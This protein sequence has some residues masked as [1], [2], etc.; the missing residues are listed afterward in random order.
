VSALQFPNPWTAPLNFSDSLSHDLNSPNV[1]V[2]ETVSERFIAEYVDTTQDVDFAYRESLF[3]AISNGV[4]DEVTNLLSNGTY[5]H[6]RDGINNSPL[7][8][9]ILKGN[10]T[11]VK[12]LLDY[13]ADIDAIGFKRKTPLHLATTSKPLV[14][15]LL[16]Y[17][18]K[19]SL[20]DDEGNTALHY[21]LNPKYLWD[22]VDWSTFTNSAPIIKSIL[23]SGMDI[24]ITNRLGDSALHRVMFAAIPNSDAYMELVSEF[25]NHN[26]DLSSPMRNGLSPLYVFLNKSEIF[27]SPSNYWG[28]G[29]PAWVKR[30]YMCLEKFLAAGADPNTIFCSKPLIIE[31]L[32]N[33]I[34]MEDDMTGKA[35]LKLI[36]KASIDVLG[37]AGNGPLHLALGRVNPQEN[38]R[39][40][41]WSFGT[42]E[43]T[44]ALISRNANVNQTNDD[45]ASP[46]EILL[47]KGRHKSSTIVKVAS[48]LIEAGADTMMPT[49]TGGTLFDMLDWLPNDDQNLLTKAFL[50]G[51]AVA[52]DNANN[53]P[54]QAEWVEIWRTAWEKLRWEGAKARLGELQHSRSRP[55]TAHFME[56]ASLVLTEHQLEMHKSEL[57][58]WQDKLVEKEMVTDDYEDYCAILRDCRERGIEID[59]SWYAFLLDLM[60]FK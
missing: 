44:A 22:Y 32:S 53:S 58:R 36:Q 14:Q 8:A 54:A 3:N 45:G 2:T 25:L 24:N 23:S 49:S 6:L 56:Y 50:K 39:S 55:Q 11:I 19:L 12:S 28:W 52:K 18:P 5:V 1:A 34:F 4:E 7:H 37:P 26:P 13:G 20:Q 43:I 47:T 59:V 31:C 48:L 33:G 21:L 42:Y 15:L 30:G 38:R 41:R 51:G 16:K 40:S 27:G 46:L 9:A 60:D 35:L 10:I 17:S 29:P 57:K